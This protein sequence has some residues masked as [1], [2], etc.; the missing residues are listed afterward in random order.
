VQ[1]Q[2]QQQQRPTMKLLIFVISSLLAINCASAKIFLN[3]Y[4]SFETHSGDNDEVA[5]DDALFITPLLE[6][7][8]DVR[9]IQKMAAIPLAELT[10][11]PGFAGFLTVNKTFNSNMFFWFFPAQNDAANAPLVL[12]LQG[13]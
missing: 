4:P 1:Q 7:G 8:K 13:E 3:P 11:Y 5:A 6:S 9:E 2:Q 12:W 10:G